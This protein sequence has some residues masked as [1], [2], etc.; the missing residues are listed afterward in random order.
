MQSRIIVKRDLSL[1]LGDKEERP[2]LLGD[3]EER[4]HT[5]R[6]DPYYQ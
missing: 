1:L 5:L 2:L 4:K 3:K 6:V